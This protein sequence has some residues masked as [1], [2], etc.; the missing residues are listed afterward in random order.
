M[1]SNINIKLFFK[2]AICSE[3]NENYV[4]AKISN[5]LKA[6]FFIIK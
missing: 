3:D 1:F 2:E 5:I 6:T 4:F